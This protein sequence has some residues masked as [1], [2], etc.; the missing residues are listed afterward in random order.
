MPRERRRESS[1]GIY[2]IVLQ[3]KEGLGLFREEKDCRSFQYLLDSKLEDMGNV[4]IWNV[5]IWGR[6]IFMPL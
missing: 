3:G 5:L 1:T 6:I 2:H 4:D